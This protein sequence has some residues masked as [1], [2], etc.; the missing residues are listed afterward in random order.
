MEKIKIDVKNF[1]IHNYLCFLNIVKVN[2]LKI[3]NC[4]NTFHILRTKIL[5]IESLINFQYI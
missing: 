4:S 5:L 1:L 3:I 2:T